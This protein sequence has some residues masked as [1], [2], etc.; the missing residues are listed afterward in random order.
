MSFEVNFLYYEKLENSFDYDRDNPKSFKKVY[1]K[2]EEEY[3]YEKLISQINAQYARRDIF[4]YDTEIYEFQKKKISFKQIKDGFVI[5]NKKFSLKKSNEENLE[6]ECVEESQSVIGAPHAHMAELHPVFEPATNIAPTPPVQTTAPNQNIAV[7]VVPKPKKIIK[8]VIFSPLTVENRRKFPYKF[9]VN[10]N[11]PVYAEKPVMNGI[12]TMID[13]VD[14]LG[15]NV[16]VPD[17]HFVSENISLIGDSEADF[18]QKNSNNV[19]KR[20]NWSGVVKDGSVPKL[21]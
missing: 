10:K 8:T 11:Y 21:R 17:E 2:L 16:T 4:V 19:D 12:G 18:S 7:N 3:S 20:L 6:L 15:Q 5:K 1:G 13:T 9:T 14:D